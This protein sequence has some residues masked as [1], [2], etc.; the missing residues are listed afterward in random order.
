MFGSA[1]RVIGTLAFTS[2]L[3]ATPGTALAAAPTPKHCGQPLLT[4]P[5]TRWAD[6]D[7]YK[8]M[9]GGSF[10]GSL[11]GWSLR[12]GAQRVRGG[13]PFA[14]DGS[15]G[16][17]SLLL[18]E[19]A[20]ATSPQTCVDPSY[21]TFRLFARAVAKRAT[22]TVS[23]VYHAASGSTTIRVAHLKLGA[24]WRLTAPL[25]TEAVLA[26]ART[27]GTAKL[28]LRFTASGGSV[29]ID[30]VFVDPHGRSG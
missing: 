15:V 23:V 5:F 21:R 22:L 28:Q 13:A 16:R 11:G 19:G 8:P 30:D 27:G 26:S 7:L 20:V 18:P 12:R 6:H 17:H 10:D 2:L 3:A 24:G 25:P 29:R 1:R 4:E 9:P 14:I